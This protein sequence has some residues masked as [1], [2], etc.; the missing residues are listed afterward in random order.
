MLLKTL[1]RTRTKT[2]LAL[3]A[4]LLLAV[5]SLR[6]AEDWYT[7]VTTRELIEGVREIVFI[8]RDIIEITVDPALSRVQHEEPQ[9]ILNYQ[10]PELFTITSATD[11]NYSDGA[12]PTTVGIFNAIKYNKIRNL[13]ATNTLGNINHKLYW[14]TFYLYL[15]HPMESGNTY[16]VAVDS[17]DPDYTATAELTYDEE[18]TTSKIF[19]INQGGYS[20][21]ATKRYVY[22]G[23]WAGDQGPVDYSA[24]TT[25]D[26]VD[27]ASGAV[28][29]QG[30]PIEVRTMDDTAFSGEHVY[31]M[32]IADLGPGA[33]QIAVPGLCRSDPFTVGVDGIREAYYHT[34]RAFFH[35]RCGQEFRE[36]WTTFVKPACHTAVWESGHLVDDT[37]SLEHF[38]ITDDEPYEPQP[39]EQKMTGLKGGY[40]D[41]ADYDA[42]TY[43]LPATAGLLMAYDCFPDAFQDGDLNIPE[44]G[45]GIPDILDEAVWGLMFFM[46]QQ[47]PDGSIPMG[48]GNECDAFKQQTGGELPPY[49]ILPVRRTGTAKFAA[50]AALLARQLRPWDDSTAQ[51][52]LDAAA[53]AY[54]W[55]RTNQ[56]DPTG[57]SAEDVEKDNRG[58]DKYMAWAA[59]ELYF[60]TGDA[61]YHADWEEYLAD[62]SPYDVV[63]NW[64]A[65]QMRY[66]SYLTCTDQP[67]DQAIKDDLVSWLLS[68]NN[69]KRVMAD[70]E[71]GSYRN[72]AGSFESGGWGNRQGINGIGHALL[73]YRTTGETKY[74]DHISLNADW[75]MGCNPRGRTFVTNFGYR[76]PTR[77]E[78]SIFLYEQFNPVVW[79]RT[80]TGIPM[81]G[82]GPRLVDN[83]PPLPSARSW[84]DQWGWF[85]EIYAEFTVGQTLGP[86]G[87]VYAWLYGLE[88]ATVDA[89]QPR[90]S[91]FGIVKGVAMPSVRLTADG[92]R[93]HS[94]THEPY[95]VELFDLGGR[96]MR[97]ARMPRGGTHVVRTAEMASGMSVVKV[98]CDGRTF[99]TRA[100][101]AR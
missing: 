88:Q 49:G 31:E 32:D 45:N 56:G 19:K 29:K 52:H 13:A 95:R 85:A 58:A 20:S 76:Y 70:N 4:M 74:L 93:I 82:I 10:R 94:H 23:W 9:G 84:K 6:A 28:V 1:N 44:S 75:H 83:V 79:G 87:M 22:L 38:L 63:R 17:V 60:A 80:V 3:G 69:H 71:A 47:Y 77:P 61:S 100:V 8:S 39:G 33:Y 53:A 27:A 97:R 18:T 65:K 37:A 101:V 48:R 67:T 92:V 64:K 2:P 42:F 50:T 25:F 14:Y 30:A 26:V 51:A 73:L 78:I 62:P 68:D 59:T 72:S 55:A 43:H 81:Y 11:P 91:T 54:A 7:F 5:S 89:R 34:L 16:T 40:H 90:R 15:P 96:L 99:A 57:L 46:S 41:A 21:A 24:Y 98:H 35:Q 66:Y 36:P 12:N 86:A